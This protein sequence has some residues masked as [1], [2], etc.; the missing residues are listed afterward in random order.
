MVE[1]TVSEAPF[2]LHLENDDNL[3]EVR[4]LQMYFPIRR[5]FFSQ[6]TGYTK[7]VDRVSFDIRRGETLGLVGESGCGKSTI[8]R[9]IVRA[10]ELTGGQMLY[11]HA[12]GSVND[13]ARLEGDGLRRLRK[14]IRMI[15]QDP[16]SSLNPRM[17][18]FD[19]ISE[20]LQVNAKMSRNDIRDRVAYL[21]QR[22]GLRPEYM[23]RYPHAF[24]GGERQ[25][26][27]VARALVTN[28]RLIVADEAVSALD[29][30]VRAQILNLL[31]ELQEE[32]QLTYLFI[33]HDLGVIRH[34]C[35]RVAVMY[36][37]KL[38][39]TAL[40]DD[41]YRTPKHPYT[42]A[43]LSSVPIANPRQR[44]DRDRIRLTGD[45]ADP[46]NPPSGCY[47]HPRCAYAQDRCSEQEPSLLPPRKNPGGERL[48][49][50]H[51]ADELSLMG[52]IRDEV[53]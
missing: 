39:E 36:V 30:S 10:Y 44:G 47:F 33:S 28:P 49:A 48:V 41:L 3:L 24:S 15:F 12:D 25:R 45:V 22:V 31:E 5:G 16:Y 42:E 32:F 52:V 26:I 18:V 35:D 11:R 29:V 14:D 46:S 40:I 50:C 1:Q 37:G 8:G 53:E 34:I 20:A 9:C 51:F 17:T 2:N 19:N 4:D 13:L 43:L 38:V 23:S 6:V 27:V 21:L 7:A